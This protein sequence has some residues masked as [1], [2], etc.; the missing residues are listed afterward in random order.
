MRDANIAATA[1]LFCS[2]FTPWALN[3][4]DLE[5]RRQHLINI[6]KFAADTGILIFSQ[7]SRFAYRWTV[8]G[9]RDRR[10][11][12]R[13]V[14]LPGFVK[15]SDERARDLPGQGQELVSPVLGTL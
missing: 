1:D 9:D 7:Y 4:N 14:V 8:P 6:M 2:A 12:D 15:V 10:G 13:I 11:L 3:P 5:T